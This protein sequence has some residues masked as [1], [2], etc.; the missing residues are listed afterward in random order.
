MLYIYIVVRMGLPNMW[1]F[2]PPG[3]SHCCSLVNGKPLGVWV[4]GFGSILSHAG[5]VLSLGGKGGVVRMGLPNIPFPTVV[6]TGLCGR[7]GFAHW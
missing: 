4:S 7:F 1:A 2:I 3:F 5:I 6:V